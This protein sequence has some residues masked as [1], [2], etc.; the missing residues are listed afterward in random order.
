[1]ESLGNTSSRLPLENPSGREAS[2]CGG[3]VEDWSV[4]RVQLED[5][6]QKIL[7]SPARSQDEKILASFG[8]MIGGRLEKGSILD[9]ESPAKAMGS[10]ISAISAPLSGSIGSTVAKTA[11][12]ALGNIGSGFTLKNVLNGNIME[13]NRLKWG[14][15][16]EI[17][18]KG[19]ETII[20]SRS[21][22]EDQKSLARLGL[23]IAYRDGYRK[24]MVN[25]RAIVMDAIAHPLSGPV[26][27][28]L[29]RAILSA[30]REGDSFDSSLMLYRGL[31]EIST[32]SKVPDTVRK[33]AEEGK[34]ADPGDMIPDPIEERKAMLPFMKKIAS[35]AQVEEER[36]QERQKS[37]KREE[38]Q[39]FVEDCEKSEPL[40]VDVE[41]E[42]VQIDDIRLNRR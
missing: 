16:D 14:Y 22:S 25:A 12:Q 5:E 33:I 8:R 40:T 26:A 11:L 13:R 20:E 41:Q 1:M 38:L 15:K 34:N 21:T 4:T 36:E 42:Y 10:I 6:F 32:N 28:I 30:E 2:P 31:D 3:T 39:R 29:A 7:D 17:L 18:S 35:V 9:D 37:V 23:A 27:G 24:T 19:F